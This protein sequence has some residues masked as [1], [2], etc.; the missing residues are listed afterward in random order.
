M[1]SHTFSN[2]NIPLLKRKLKRLTKNIAKKS[3]KQI[4]DEIIKL[5][6][7]IDKDKQEKYDLNQFLKNI[8]KYTDPEELAAEMVNELIDKII[9]HTPD[10]SSGHR[11]QK[12]EIYYKTVGIINIATDE[13]L[14]AVSSRKD[15]CHKQSA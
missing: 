12:I 11:K 6:N 13:K 2:L 9:V 8:R 3:E 1:Y 4:K 15:C 5:Q 10:K 7:L 14:I